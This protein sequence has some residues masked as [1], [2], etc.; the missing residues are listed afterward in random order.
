MSIAARAA[1]AGALILLAGCSPKQMALNRMASALASATS[2]YESDNDVEFVRV[3]APS[4]LKTIEML[5]SQSPDHP[6]LLLTACSGF[7]QYSYGFLHVESEVRAADTAA[8]AD[9]RSRAGRMYQ[10]ARGYCLHGLEVRHPGMTLKALAA[11]PAAAL[12]AATLD[13]VPWLYWTAAAWGAD[14]AL[15]PNQML[16]ITEVASV[17]ALLN[18]AKALNDS[19]EQG[20][21]YEGLIAFDAL[22]PLLG[23]SPAAARADFDKAM[24]LSDRKSVFAYVALAA[25]I[26]DPAEKKRLLE[27]ALAIDVST[28]TSRRL[29]NLIAQRFARALLSAVR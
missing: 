9:L 2:V 18:R 14:L 13:D 25:T 8:A 27:S 11:D 19:W 22:P 24:Q 6:E 1:L 10:R 26:T 7:T 12:K 15:A 16:R 21:I 3:A 29:T 17:R 4:T 5:L 23:G 28:L 20:A